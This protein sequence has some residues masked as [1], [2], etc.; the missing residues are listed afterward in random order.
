MAMRFDD[1]VEVTRQN[2][3]SIPPEQLRVSPEINGRADLPDVEGMIQDIVKNGQEQPILIR[4][5]GGFPVIVDGHC[6]W[7]A[8]S[9]INERKLTPVPLRVACVSF[10]GNEIDAFKAAVRTNHFRYSSTPMDDANNI[11]RLGKYGMTDEE[12]ALFYFPVKNGEKPNLTWVR[13]R[14][15]LI[16]LTPEGSKAVASGRVKPA[17]ARAIAKLSAKQQKELLEKPGKI[18]ASDVRK[19]TGKP[20]KMS[21][22]DVKQTLDD[23]ISDRDID[24]QKIPKFV[25]DWL[26]K[27]RDKI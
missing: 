6:R 25:L 22:H 11:V 20:E 16:S 21:L 1:S 3:Y 2:S 9:D 17:A 14:R 23:R 5:D 24:G 8:I 4:N 10:Q 19:A 15:E 12:I 18:K 27:L 7:R 26:C 13:G